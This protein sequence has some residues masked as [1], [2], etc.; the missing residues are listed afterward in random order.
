MYPGKKS[1]KSITRRQ[2]GEEK[3]VDFYIPIYIPVDICLDESL[4]ENYIGT[5]CEIDM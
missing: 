1:I 4:L 3:K 2:C 5:V